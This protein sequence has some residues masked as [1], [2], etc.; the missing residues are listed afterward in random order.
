M[1][2]GHPTNSA[3]GPRNLVPEAGLEPARLTARDFKSLESTI[4]P[5]GQ[6]LVS[7]ERFELPPPGPKP[8]TLP[9]YAI[10]SITSRHRPRLN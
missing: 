8:G 2:S 5:L 4:S 7:L 6:N 1:S 9:D 10:G 3:S